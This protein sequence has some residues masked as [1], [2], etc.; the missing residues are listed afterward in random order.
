M[1][2]E[3]GRPR[4]FGFIT[5]STV[6]EASSALQALDGQVKQIVTLNIR[7]SLLAMAVL[8]RIIIYTIC[9]Y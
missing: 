2:R 9:V 6:E 4:G 1:D 3:T 8:F 5:F 7:V